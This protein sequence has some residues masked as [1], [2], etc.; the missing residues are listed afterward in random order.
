MDYAKPISAENNIT[1]GLAMYR[2][3][4]KPEGAIFLYV[5]VLSAQ[6]TN[7]DSNLTSLNY[8]NPGG[9]DEATIF[10]WQVALNQTQEFAG[11]TDFDMISMLLSPNNTDSIPLVLTLEK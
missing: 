8:S 5:K 6:R 2:P 3:N 10:A 11:L 1:L 9:S 4:K 7:Q